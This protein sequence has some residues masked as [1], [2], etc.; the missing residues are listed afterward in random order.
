[1]NQKN[2]TFVN[3]K[4][5]GM[6]INSNLKIRKIAG[7]SVV[8]MQGNGVADMTK[9][10]SLNSTSEYLWNNLV[11][12]DFELE[13]VIKLLLDEFNVEEAIARKDAENWIEKLIQNKVI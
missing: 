6:R 13:D 10:I 8:I 3:Q 2:S 7:E 12:K 4:L 9:V 11:G 5:T 1:M